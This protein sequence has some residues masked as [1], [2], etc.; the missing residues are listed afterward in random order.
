MEFLLWCNRMDSV[1]GAQGRR[2]NP[3]T[4]TVGYRYGIATGLGQSCGSDLNPGPGTP[5]TAGSLKRKKYI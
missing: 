2:Y 4:G 1:L 3:R 5:Y